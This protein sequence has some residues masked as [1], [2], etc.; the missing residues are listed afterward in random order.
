[1]TRPKLSVYVPVYDEVDRLPY[2]LASVRWADE[3][4]VLD[5]GGFPEVRAIAEQYAD[6]VICHKFQ[7]FGRLRNAGIHACSHEWILSIDADEFCTPELAEEIRRTLQAPD[8]EAYFIPRRNWFMG[9]WIRHSGWY[10]DYAQ[11]KLFRRGSMQYWNESLVH[12]GWEVAGPIGYLRNPLINFSFR[13][14]SDVLRKIDRYSELGSIQLVASRAHISILE[15]IFRGF[16][17]FLRIYFLK[18]GL[19]DG[20]A[21]FMIAI[22]NFFGTFYR[23]AKA[24]WKVHG[25]DTPPPGIDSLSKRRL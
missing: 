5:T 16:W 1:M 6:K 25:W 23:Y 15:A 10:P 12:E 4:V 20:R 2:A 9:R 8:A 17:A 18:L 13:N 3:V 22:N 21:G 11:P 7:G 24:A 19:L 14:L